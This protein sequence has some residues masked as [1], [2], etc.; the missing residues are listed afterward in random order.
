MRRF[1]NFLCAMVAMSVPLSALATDAGLPEMLSGSATGSYWSGSRMLD[2][3]RGL[4]ATSLWLKG[5]RAVGESRVVAEGWL[6]SEDLRRGGRKEGQLREAFL[7]TTVGNV[8]LRVGRQVLVWGRA[9]QI[10][11]T[12]NLT[13]RDYTLLVPEAGDDRLGTHAVQVQPRFGEVSVTATWLPRFRPSVTPIPDAIEKQ[14]PRSARQLALKVDSS[15]GG[16]IDW[17]VSW[18]SGFDLTPSLA[19]RA[20]GGAEARYPRISVIGGDFAVPLGRVGLRGEFAYTRTEDREG[21]DPL[22]KNPFLFGVL[23]ADRTFLAYLNVN[24]QYYVYCVSRYSDPREI[25]DAGLRGLAVSQ[26]ALA[27][28]VDRVEQGIALRVSN[29]WWNETLEAE[30]AAVLAFGGRGHIVKPKVVYAVNDHLRLTV[31]ADVYRGR[32]DAAYGLL[33]HNSVA[34]GELRF[35]F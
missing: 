33:E 21:T 11:P 26:A 19:L 10:N 34:Y 24:F 6:R 30:L 9:D 14:I 29:K 17:S 2:G 15:G 16:G 18:F 31:G 25:A 5:Q 20:T 7:V 28:Q 23:G 32:S 3:D 8:D 22:K 13:P 1:L 4:P 27:H 12:D 35:Y